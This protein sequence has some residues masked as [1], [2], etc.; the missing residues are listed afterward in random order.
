MPALFHFRFPLDESIAKAELVAVGLWTDISVRVLKLP[1]CEQL[2]VEMLGGGEIDATKI[3][4]AQVCVSYI[5]NSLHL[6]RKY[7]Q[8][9]VRGHYLFR[10]ANSFPRAKLEENCELRY[11][12]SQI[13]AIVFIIH[14]F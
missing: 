1:S 10:E 12:R 5:N 4:E 9:C 8:I 6:A 7:A 11:F 2:H 13:E 14:R 3:G